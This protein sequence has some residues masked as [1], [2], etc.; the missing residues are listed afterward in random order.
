[1][2]TTQLC[3]FL[4]SSIDLRDV[5]GITY[6]ILDFLCKF[7][8]SLGSCFCCDFLTVCKRILERYHMDRYRMTLELRKYFQVS[9]S[10]RETKDAT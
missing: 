9:S 8:L 3:D 7:L 10:L 5:C 4:A 2:A 6:D 1:M